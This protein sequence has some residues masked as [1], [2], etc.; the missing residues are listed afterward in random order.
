MLLHYELQKFSFKPLRFTFNALEKKEQTSQAPDKNDPS[1][2]N[3]QMAL[4]QY[5]KARA[6]DLSDLQKIID[7]D[8]SMREKTG[9]T[10][11]EMDRL[12]G[13]AEKAKQEI[14]NTTHDP[15]V[16]RVLKGKN[17]MQDTENLRMQQRLIQS[18]ILKHHVSSGVFESNNVSVEN[19]RKKFFDTHIEALYKIIHTEGNPL[20]HNQPIDREYFSNLAYKLSKLYDKANQENTS[21]GYQTATK[22]IQELMVTE[23]PRAF[24]VQLAREIIRNEL[25]LPFSEQKIASPQALSSVLQAKFAKLDPKYRTALPNGYVLN[26][27]DSGISYQVTKENDSTCTTQVLAVDDYGRKYHPEFAQYVDQKNQVAQNN[28]QKK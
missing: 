6:R 20:L 13:F 18:I 28:H 17:T 23:Y 12:S 10:G 21:R 24:E 11:E 7:K 5:A 27:K 8:Q 16:L 25:N 19:A 2:R 4:D 9:L 15:D 1:E 14:L 3:Y 26:F 22:K